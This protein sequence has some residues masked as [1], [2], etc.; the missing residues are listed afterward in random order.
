MIISLR[1]IYESSE[2]ITSLT[3]IHEIINKQEKKGKDFAIEEFIQTRKEPREGGRR[4]RGRK[5]E[6]I[7]Q[8]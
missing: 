3:W 1:I 5:R 4:E 8:L 6:S 2:M 7:Y